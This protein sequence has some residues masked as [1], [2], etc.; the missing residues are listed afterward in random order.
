MI[1]LAAVAAVGAGV[2]L[3]DRLTRKPR[4]TAATLAGHAW[5]IAELAP[6]GR[7]TLASFPVPEGETPPTFETRTNAWRWREREVPAEPPPGV[8]RVLLIGDSVTYGTGVAEA[9][10]FGDR[11]A[12]ALDRCEVVNA[13]L[14]GTTA[15]EALELL[16][17]RGLSLHPT[18]V[19][20]GVMTND[21]RQSGTAAV[22]AD[23]AAVARFGG[24]LER[25]VDLCAGAGVGVV[26]WGNTIVPGGA[27][28][29][30]LPLRREMARVAEARRV[31][32]VDLDAVYTRSPATAA[33]IAAVVDTPG[34]WLTWWDNDTGAPPSRTALHVDWAHPSAAGHARLAAALV[35]AVREVLARRPRL[36]TAR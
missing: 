24:A 29:P 28:D 30:L 16:R 21:A 18:V 2:W 34:H 11:L 26:L 12:A 23:D 33:E 17:T 4:P 19:V 7:Y 5:S 36:S 8:R 13:G 10:R 9:E 1:L 3:A 27:A 6:N 31:P 20:V 22:G 25:V 15:D 14:P 32:Y 35:P